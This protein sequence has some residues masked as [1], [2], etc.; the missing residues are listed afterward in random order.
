MKNNEGQQES[1]YFSQ[2]E[3]DDPVSSVGLQ[4][5]VFEAEPVL[6]NFLEEAKR[7]RDGLE[8]LEAEGGKKPFVP[9][10]IKILIVHN[11]CPHSHAGTEY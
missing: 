8:E 9:F 5:V 11:I 7:V 2:D 4:A 10:V 1:N 6:E 3:E